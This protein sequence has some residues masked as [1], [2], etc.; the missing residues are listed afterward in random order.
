MI[1]MTIHEKS[2]RHRYL[3]LLF[4][5]YRSNSNLRI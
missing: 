3:W 2:S 1:L 5:G 4:I